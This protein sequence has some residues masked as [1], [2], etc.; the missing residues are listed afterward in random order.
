MHIDDEILNEEGIIDQQKIDLVGRMGGNWYVR[1][2]GEAL[3]EVPKP[4]RQKGIGVDQLPQR[5][6]ESHILSGNDL[7]MLGN[8]ESIPGKE[9]FNVDLSE[10][11]TPK[12]WE[13][14]QKMAK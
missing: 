14:Q 4:V 8:V 2:S 5:I 3:F 6:R 7:G 13:E 11:E 10:Q 1:A 12:N 9:E